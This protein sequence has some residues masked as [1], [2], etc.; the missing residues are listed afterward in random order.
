MKFSA[1]AGPSKRAHFLAKP[2]GLE[3][4]SQYPFANSSERHAAGQA[5]L[6][7]IVATMF[8]LG[9]LL[10]VYVQLGERQE[11]TSLVSATGTQA[12]DCATLQTAIALVQN[13]GANAEIVVSISSDANVTGKIMRFKD[14][15]CYF[16]ANDMNAS[17]FKGNVKVKS[18][19]GV[20]S[21][22]NA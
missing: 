9:V 16:S 2:R 10:A 12:R 5:S 6:E 15:Y 21:L 1:A 8:L 20:V 14:H 4:I 22:E 11:Q 18:I 19:N 17:I 13:S 3:N 7:A